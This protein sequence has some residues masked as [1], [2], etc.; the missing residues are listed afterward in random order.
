MNDAVDHRLPTILVV[1]PD[2]IIRMALA[3]YL[4]ECGF[5]VIEANDADEARR[6]AESGTPIDVLFTEVDLPGDTDGFALA[7]WLRRHHAGTKVLLTS[8]VKRSAK[9]AGELCEDGPLLAKP[10]DHRDLEHRIRYLLSVEQ[11]RSA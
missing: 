6:V 9:Q 10:Y 2:V 1:E 3:A 11:N 4:R 5:K 7:T 8:G